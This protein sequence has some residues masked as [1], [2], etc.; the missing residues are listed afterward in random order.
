MNAGKIVVLPTAVTIALMPI[1]TRQCTMNCAA[2]LQGTE[3]GEG[4]EGKEVE[5]GKE[6]EEESIGFKGCT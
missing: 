5:E 4:K 1:G 2:R 3:E 6:E